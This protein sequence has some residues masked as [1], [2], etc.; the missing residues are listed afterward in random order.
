MQKLRTE[1]V[2]SSR[3]ATSHAFHSRLMDPML[4]DLERVAETIHF[5]PP[6]IP[7]I[8]NV[9]GTIAGSEVAQARYWVD[10]AR[11]PV[12]FAAG[13]QTLDASGVEAFLEIG[14]DPVLLSLGQMSVS[15]SALWV[16]SLRGGA[17]ERRHMLESLA[18]LWQLGRELNWCGVWAGRESRRAL[19]PTY[20]FQRERYWR[21][22]AAVERKAHQVYRISWREQPLPRENPSCGEWVVTGDA[23]VANEF[24][25]ACADGGIRTRCIAPEDWPYARGPVVFFS[26]ETDPVA[27][28]RSLLHFLKSVAPGLPVW[29]VTL[30]AVAVG[31]EGPDPAQGALWGLARC[32]ALERKPGATCLIDLDRDDFET[33][34]L[35]TQVIAV[36]SEENQ[37]AIRGTTLFAARLTPLALERGRIALR[38][39]ARYLVTGGSG[40]IGLRLAERLVERGAR[41]L[42]LTARKR[43]GPAVERRIQALKSVTV[44]FVEADAADE[45]AMERIISSPGLPIRGIFHTAGTQSR[46]ELAATTA[47]VLEDAM[48]G[49]AL[50]A[51]VLERLATRLDLDLFVFMSSVASV[52][53][54]P[55]QACYAAANHVL[56]C[57]AQRRRSAGLVA[58]AIDWSAWAGGGMAGA[59]DLTALSA[60]GIRPLDPEAALDV[61]E[62][63]TLSREPQIVVADADW[64]RFHSVYNARARRPLLDELTKSRAALPNKP[65]P[66]LELVGTRDQRRAQLM[67]LIARELASVLGKTNMHA[68]SPKAGFFELGMDSLM[69]VELKT[70]LARITG[71]DIRTTA[72][73]DYASITALAEYLMDLTGVPDSPQDTTGE[74]QRKL[75][76]LEELLELAEP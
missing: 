28:S 16:S 3:L 43:P 74:L 63:A 17:P 13:M 26:R 30:R 11:Q 70:R 4:R 20:P 65:F 55:E 38:S 59:D 34:R 71:L 45:T 10:H 52:W 67:E 35:A 1:G 72:V 46:R 47:A 53:G 15:R 75:E 22:T 41:H 60:M 40:E 2:R 49:K 19:L 68:V 54:S 24:S 51:L 31:P 50:G 27:A 56:D 21:E 25:R 42:V 36:Q 9:T 61:L 48:R 69:A 58:T 32:A 23:G 73:F 7:F 37:W 6:Q 5:F 64:D 33:L 29:V 39:D 57:V 44:E 12:A 18:G 76:R 62:A 8:S 14:P 66:Q